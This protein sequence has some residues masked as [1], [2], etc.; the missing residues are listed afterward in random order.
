MICHDSSSPVLRVS[1]LDDLRLHEAEIVRRIGAMPNGGRLL[2]VDP[3]RLLRDINVE[4]ASACVNESRAVHATL[5]A[6]TG[7]EHTYDLIASSSPGG[8]IQVMVD[9]IFA[10]VAR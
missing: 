9:G 1:S 6:P 4:V 10:K 2:L 5:F 3:Q 7:R 8:Q